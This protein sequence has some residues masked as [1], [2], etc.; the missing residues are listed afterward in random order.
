M[1]IISL[2]KESTM[3]D[4]LVTSY[5]ILEDLCATGPIFQIFLAK[6]DKFLCDRVYPSSL[7]RLEGIWPGWKGLGYASQTEN[8]VHPRFFQSSQ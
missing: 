3:T 1:G 8:P 6:V 5:D 7:A 2:L 4:Y